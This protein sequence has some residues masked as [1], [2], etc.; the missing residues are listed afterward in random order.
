MKSPD[1]TGASD[2]L[3]RSRGCH[4]ENIRFRSSSSRTKRADTWLNIRRWQGCYT[5]SK[6]DEEAEE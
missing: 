6:T 1:L 2:N 3:Q 4:R 5:Q